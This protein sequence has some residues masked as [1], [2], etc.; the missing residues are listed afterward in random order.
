MVGV[1]LANTVDQCL[2]YKELSGDC[3][4]LTLCSLLS[5]STHHSPPLT[6]CSL[7]SPPLRVP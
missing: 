4:S 6:L 1:V 5:P 2:E 3:L 7:L